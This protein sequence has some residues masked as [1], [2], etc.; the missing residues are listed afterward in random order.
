MASAQPSPT[1]HSATVIHQIHLPK[2]TALLLAYAVGFYSKC[3]TIEGVQC[4][5]YAKEQAKK[6][7]SSRHTRREIAVD[8]SQALPGGVVQ[9]CCQYTSLV[10]PVVL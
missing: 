2:Y 1:L 7:G 9:T 3:S 5:A 4:P 10:S 8:R 6:V